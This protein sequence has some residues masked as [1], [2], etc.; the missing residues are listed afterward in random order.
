MVSRLLPDLSETCLLKFKKLTKRKIVKSRKAHWKLTKN[1]VMN[2]ILTSVRIFQNFTNMAQTIQVC[3]L[4]QGWD[5]A[6]GEWVGRIPLLDCKN[7][8]CP[9][10]VV[11]QTLIPYSRFSW[12]DK[13]DLEDFPA[14]VFSNI[15]DFWDSEIFKNICFKWFWIPLGLFRVLG[16]IQSQE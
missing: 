1:R 13:T 15:C 10:H 6:R 4:V 5:L 12:S 3:A 14:R 16:C 2:S 7:L 9:F 8:R 11:W